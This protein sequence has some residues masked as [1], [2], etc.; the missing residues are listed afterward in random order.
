LN[1]CLGSNLLNEC[2]QIEM[3]E[4]Q[5]GGLMPSRQSIDEK[6]RVTI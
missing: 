2:G 1:D 6:K 4:A 3:N 5:S